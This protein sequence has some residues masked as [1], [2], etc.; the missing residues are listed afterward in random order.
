M[1]GLDL[2]VLKQSLA[3]KFNRDQAFQAGGGAGK[4]GSFFFFS[5]DGRF[6]IKTMT[7]DEVKLF[8]DILPAYRKHFEE[9]KDSLIAKIYGMYR[10]KI[11]GMDGVTVLLMENT[12]RVKESRDIE[13]VF[14][15]KGSTVARNVK[16]CRDE[17]TG[18]KTLKDVNFTTLKGGLPLTVNKMN[19]L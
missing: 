4:S 18:T 6:L 19:A 7:G 11:S 15:L 3:P 12:L 5:H 1:D 2:N 10:V 8:R 9:N 13:R 16:I 17:Y 14:D